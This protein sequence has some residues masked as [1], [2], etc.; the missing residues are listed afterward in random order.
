MGPACNEYNDA[1]ENAHYKW[2]LVVTELLNITVKDFD[3][4]TLLVTARC[5][6]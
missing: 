6:L 1:K 3:A 4:K 2:R 5:L